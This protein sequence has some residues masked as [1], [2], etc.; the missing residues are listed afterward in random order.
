[1]ALERKDVDKKYKWDLSVIYESKEAF[2]EDYKKAEKMIADFKKHEKTMTRDAESFYATLLSDAI[3]RYD[4]LV[5]DCVHFSIPFYI[6][7]RNVPFRFL[8]FS[9]FFK[10]QAD[11][12][13][14]LLPL[15]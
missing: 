12:V 15:I 6:A 11:F 1:M 14:L 3:I 13:A 8:I 10:F 5:H 9:Y 2:F 7:F 4:F